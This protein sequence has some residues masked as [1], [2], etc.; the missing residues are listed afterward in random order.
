MPRAPTNHDFQRQLSEIHEEVKTINE[1]IDK[2]MPCLAA[3]EER[4][5]SVERQGWAIWSALGAAALSLLVL[6]G[7]LVWG[8]KA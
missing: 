5:K 6:L 8:R 4:I 7:Q 3:H 1:K 2:V